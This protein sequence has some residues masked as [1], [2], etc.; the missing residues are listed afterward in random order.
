MQGFSLRTDQGSLGYCA[1]T[2]VRASSGNILVDASHVGRR[3]YFLRRLAEKGL[4]PDDID[5]VFLTHGHWDHMLNV[6]LFPNA[7]FLIHPAEREYLRHPHANDWATPHYASMVVES[8]RLQ[9]VREGDEI[10]PGLR[11]LDVPGHTRGS[12]ALLVETADGVAAVCG[13]AL[14]SAWSVRTGL[15]RL[16]FWDEQQARA[17]VA[18]LLASAERFYPGHD[19]PFRVSEGKVDYLEL[20]S[21]SV[22]NI[23]DIDSED[24]PPFSYNLQR[25]LEAQIYLPE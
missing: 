12:M 17:S 23:P 2:L 24:G 8:Y 20:T 22:T 16:I 4:T 7:T 5:T 1:V 13:D 21:V 6:D 14:P 10:G 3:Q 11:V 15:P 25:P 18:K 9:E 19:R